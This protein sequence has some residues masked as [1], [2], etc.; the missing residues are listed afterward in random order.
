MVGLALL[1][2]GVYFLKDKMAFFVDSV[3]TEG[4]VVE[5]TTIKSRSRDYYY[6]VILFKASDGLSYTFTSETGTSAAFDYSKGD[7]INIRY[8]KEDPQTA[9]MNSFIELWA[10]PMA[11][12]VAGL[13]VLLSG[14]NA[15]YRKFKRA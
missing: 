6:P 4:E 1:G 11:L 9:K 3:P 14:G 5:V 10:L 13:T 12:L 7:I 8:L 2:G 15:L